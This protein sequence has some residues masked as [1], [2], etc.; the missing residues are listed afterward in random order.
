LGG[1]VIGFFWIQAEPI[2]LWAM[3]VITS[4]MAEDSGLRE[5]L[6]KSAAH[7]RL[8]MMGVILLL[9]LRFTPKGLIPEK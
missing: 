6:L 1:F 2:G 9:V 5:H 4:G 7:M 8:M 3:D